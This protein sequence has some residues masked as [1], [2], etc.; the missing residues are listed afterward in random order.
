[1]KTM[2]KSIALSTALATAFLAF[3]G[4]STKAYQKENA[5]YKLKSNILN[6]D[7]YSYDYDYN[8]D[9]TINVF[10]VIREKKI[11]YF[12]SNVLLTDISM[13]NSVGAIG[14][15]YTHGDTT[16][17]SGKWVTTGTSWIKTMANRAGVEY[18]NYGKGGMTCAQYDT[19]DAL[20]AN[21]HDMYFYAMGI[22]DSEKK[23]V[24]TESSVL[25]HLGIIS[26]IKPD[27]SKNANTFF[28]YYGKIV[29]QMMEHA[30][31]AKHCMI[32][33]PIKGG[34]K[35]QFNNA[36]IEIANHFNIPYINPFDDEFFESNVYNNKASGHPT[37]MGYV[38]MG[39]AYERL[40]S[41]CVEENSDYF[42]YSVIN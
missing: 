16:N 3:N 41:K 2:V 42:K 14:D 1:M 6:F 22:N 26:D 9:S 38:G 34:Y 37:R 20:A 7:V 18:G 28:G 19:T 15:S 40:F 35:E 24:D 25:D 12:N 11:D 33:I 27:Y 36:I 21:A 5:L 29:A 30:P 10:D 17:S 23:Y 4:I 39:L 31:N 8:N 13:F 32:L